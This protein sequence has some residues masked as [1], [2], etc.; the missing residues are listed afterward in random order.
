M[1][2]R[3][4]TICSVCFS[5]AVV[6]AAVLGGCG[7][8]AA[9]AQTPQATAEP[10]TLTLDD[11]VSMA[12]E[13]NW[14]IQL[15]DLALAEAQ[16]AIGEAK[17]ADRLQLGLQASYSRLGPEST[18]EMPTATG[19]QSVTISPDHSHSYGVELYKSLYSSGRNQAL[20]AL[21]RL[22][23]DVRGL[24]TTVVQREISLAATTLFYG[25]ARA[26]GFV[27]VAE[28]QLNSARE[29]WRLAS[30]RF[31]AGAV[32]RFDVT[33]AEVEVADAE[34]Q[35][36]VAQTAVE[37]A[38]ASLKSLLGIA[39]T[40]PLQLVAEPAPAPL[41]LDPNLCIEMAQQRR[42][43]V[44]V[45]ETQARLA[46]VSARLAKAE[47]G[48]N[49]D[50]VGAYDRQ[51]STGFSED[52]SWNLTLSLS[53]PLSDGGASRS[54]QQQA[55]WRAEQARALAGKLAD[56]IELEVWHAYLN[57][58][59]TKHRIS[60]TAKTVEL[61]REALR[62]AEVR[63]D[64]GLATPVEVTD[65]RVALI[66]ARTNQVDAIYGYQIAKAKLLSAVNASQDD[67]E[68]LAPRSEAQ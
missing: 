67:L 16:A 60:L 41:V 54:K 21:T 3:I 29:H 68:L 11:V 17:A 43:E 50:L 25:I 6:G 10:L 57:A 35:L 7:C 13:N 34:Q 59:E 48:L 15:A 24:E 31:E 63:Y 49:L 65:A 37:T 40:R 51:S 39:V 8:R 45:A 18:M 42:E 23:V 12:L 36:I 28:E 1:T 22:N 56:D 30:A 53:K 26:I 9:L 47:R 32:P 2:P 38:K 66:A 55:L 44:K 20:L 62:I 14:N 5:I 61:A 46:M 19:T 64:A 58:E 27:E 52:H 4:S 33:R